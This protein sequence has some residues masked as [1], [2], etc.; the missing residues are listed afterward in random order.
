[1]ETK[2]PVRLSFRHYVCIVDSLGGWQSWERTAPPSQLLTCTKS[3]LTSLHTELF[4]DQMWLSISV[5]CCATVHLY[6]C[7]F[8]VLRHFKWIYEWNCSSQFVRGGHRKYQLMQKWHRETNRNY[9]VSQKINIYFSNWNE[10]KDIVGERKHKKCLMPEDLCF[11]R[12]P[13]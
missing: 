7:H 3:N 5:N 10:G 9:K 6:Y 1:L 11:M 4:V 12:A 2:D 13:V 8:C